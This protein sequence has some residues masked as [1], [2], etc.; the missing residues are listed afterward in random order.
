MTVL[1]FDT[2]IKLE[3]T[4]TDKENYGDIKVQAGG[5]TDLRDV[6]KRTAELNSDALVIFTDL[7]VK[8]PPKPDWEC[9]WLVPDSHFSVPSNIYGDVYLIPAETK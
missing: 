8:I 5:G 7:C 1:F 9:I 4:F 2:R 6:Y 3:K